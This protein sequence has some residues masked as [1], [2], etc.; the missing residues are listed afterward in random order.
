[1]T[2]KKNLPKGSEARD[3]KNQESKFREAE[4]IYDKYE[5]EDPYHRAALYNNRA[6]LYLELMNF[7][8]ATADFKRAM[9]YLE[10]IPDAKRDRALTLTG[11]GNAY[12]AKGDIAAAEESID[13]AI[14]LFEESEDD[15]FYGSALNTKA[16]IVYM[17]GDYEKASDLFAAAADVTKKFFGENED[18]RICMHNYETCLELARQ[19]KEDQ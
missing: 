11:L 2:K 13:I 10:K 6:P 19:E 1:M 16:Q 5:Y 3:C 8:K 7:D 15:V 14:A 9:T 18:Y 4:T 17:N 12:L